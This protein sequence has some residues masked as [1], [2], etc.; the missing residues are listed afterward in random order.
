MFKVAIQG[1]NMI[2][3]I[4]QSV[5]RYPER[6]AYKT[7]GQS[8]SYRELWSRAEHYAKLLKKQGQ[9]PVIIYG[10]K[11]IWVV[12]S[13]LACLLADRTYVPID[14]NTPRLR[15]GQILKQTAATLIL[16]E[17][18][19]DGVGASICKL[20]DLKQYEDAPTQLWKNEIAYIMFTSGTTGTPKG[21]PI[22]RTNLHNFII[23]ISQLSPL[24]EYDGAKVLNQASFS[25]D[26]SVADFYYA[27]CNGHTLYAWIND[28]VA[29]Y[30][31][32]FELF[33]QEQIQVAV[34]TPTLADLC[35]LN[36]G[37]RTENYPALSCIYFCGER[38]QKKTVQKL[39]QAFPDLKIINA[40][41]PTEATSAVSAVL[42]DP[43]MLLA[44][45]ELPVGLQEHLATDVEIIDGEI[46]LKGASVFAGY[47]Q[48][49]YSRHYL[50]NGQ[51]CFYTGDLGFWKNG[52]LY[53]RGRKDRQIKWK[54]YRIEL[55]DIEC[56]IR[57]LEGVKECA[58]IS[59]ASTGGV[60]KT[61][62][63]FVVLE[64]GYSVDQIRRELSKRLPDYMLPKSLQP[65]LAMP[66]NQNGKINR[67]ELAGL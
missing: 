20:E 36:S 39:W 49:G 19:I 63:A 59:S 27:L 46:I 60:V 33:Q 14:L 40:Y 48:A 7:E 17:Q 47:L 28:G 34:M 1:V 22:S 67:K 61:V 54:G 15:L 5:C 18:S 11:E 53:C 21:V 6:I 52:R 64:A 41:G 9:S 31:R 42:I 37:W 23:W 25:F 44:Q 16:T 8:I 32:L 10:Q 45:E 50:E 55:D 2:S 43:E 66:L 58:V 30:I 12:I 38:L 29:D 62:K 26:L 57:Q 65:I 35:L 4:Y 56:N 13:I 51:N 24:S 3:L